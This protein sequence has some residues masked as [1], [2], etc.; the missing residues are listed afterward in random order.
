MIFFLTQATGM[1]YGINA[2]YEL[3]FLKE[4]ALATSVVL[5]PVYRCSIV[6]LH[7]SFHFFQTLQ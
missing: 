2:I 6:P 1:G 7:I 5:D 3:E 4:V